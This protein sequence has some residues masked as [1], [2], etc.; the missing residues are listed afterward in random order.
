MI[1]SRSAG[2]GPRRLGLAATLSALIIAAFPSATRVAGAGE[3]HAVVVTDSGPVRGAIG[4]TAITYLGIP[5]AEA[6]VGDL[7]WRAPRP[8]ARWS[9]VLDATA[10]GRHCPQP[11]SALDPAASEDCLFLNVYVPRGDGRPDGASVGTAPGPRAGRPVMVWIHGGGNTGGTGE[12]YDPTPLGETGGVVVVTLNYRLGPFGFLAHPALRA[13]GD[14]AGNLGVMDQQQ[15]LR[16]VR[17]NVDRFGGDPGNVTLAGESSGGLDTLTH[18]VSPLSAGLM[19]RVIVQSGAYGLDTP[20]LASSE[21][22]GAAFA[23][24]LG[25]VDQSAACLRSTSTVDVLASAAGGASYNRSTVDGRVLPETQLAAL[26]AGRINRVTVLQGANSH[27]GRFFLPP[28]L[29]ADGYRTVLALIAA[30]T[31]KSLDRIHAA[32]PL[33]ASPFEAASAA[34]GD[35]AYACSAS[36]VNKLLSL[37]VPTYGYEFDDAGASPLGAT[38]SAELR[39]LFNLSFGGIPAG[40][41]GSLPAPSQELA[42]TMRVYWTSFAR[43]GDPTSGGVPGWRPYADGRVQLLGAPSPSGASAANYDVRHNCAFWNQP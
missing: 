9:G 1:Q 6:P 11:G 42:R 41:P 17:A 39:Y 12:S 24:R 7:R 3:A 10:F 15:A 19:H 35:A 5:Y 43:S 8:R 23:T 28:T 14:A 36:A 29:T 16:W 40:G 21:A 34:Y 2:R 30:A 22:L 18:L 4:P 25:C 38:H 32:Y 20:S 33:G 13:D 37:R 26:R 27:E 31:G